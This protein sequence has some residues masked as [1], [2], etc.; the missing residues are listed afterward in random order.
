[1]REFPIATR[2][3]HSPE[4][5]RLTLRYAIWVEET[6]DG[7]ETYGVKITEE[8]TAADALAPGLTMCAQRIY[9]LTETLANGTVTPAGL[10]DVLADWL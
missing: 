7:L 2:V 6:P 3:I 5:R 8:E 4:N 10:M 9:G 1:M